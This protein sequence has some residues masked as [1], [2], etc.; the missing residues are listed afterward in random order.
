[1]GGRTVDAAGL[2]FICF[3]RVG[4]QRGGDFGAGRHVVLTQGRG[5]EPCLL[6]GWSCPTQ[7]RALRVGRAERRL[8]GPEGVD[9]NALP[10]PTL[11]KPSS[12][13]QLPCSPGLIGPSPLPLS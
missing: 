10:L 13:F 8:L 1:M 7:R 12:S 6:G 2:G 4:G 9:G 5:K 3:V 11:L